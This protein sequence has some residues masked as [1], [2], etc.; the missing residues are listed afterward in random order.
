M[1]FTMITLY[2]NIVVLYM[3]TM[4]RSSRRMEYN[5]AYPVILFPDDTVD[6]RATGPHVSGDLAGSGLLGRDNDDRPGSMANG[7]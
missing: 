2:V 6:I 3:H 4:G 1:H 5:L 7:V